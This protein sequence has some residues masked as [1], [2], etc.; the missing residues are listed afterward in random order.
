MLNAVDCTHVHVHAVCLN[1]SALGAHCM[2]A[3]H[4]QWRT[5]STS[6]PSRALRTRLC[7]SRSPPSTSGLALAPTLTSPFPMRCALL[8]LW[9]APLLGHAKTLYEGRV[10]AFAEHEA[11]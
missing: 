5:T 8:S 4:R 6:S 10:H 3:P 2:C 9:A 1:C 7:R 11:P